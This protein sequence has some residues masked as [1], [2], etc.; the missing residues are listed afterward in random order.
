MRALDLD[1]VDRK[2]SPWAGWVLLGVAVLL[3]AEMVYSYAKL[4]QTSSQRS[5]RSTP[6]IP[7]TR[8]S[9]SAGSRSDERSGLEAQ[10]AEAAAVIER[11]SLPWPQ[12]F[13]ALERISLDRVALLSIQ[14]DPERRVVTLVGEA[15]QYG[16]VL[17]YINGLNEVPVFGHARL[18]SHEIKQ[19][20]PQRPVVFTVAASW[21]IGP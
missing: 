14:P 11:L 5:A 1:F 6:G 4:V 18:V 12:L 3:A 9:A 13:Q 7:M 8:I 2:R 20:D 19:D 21:K 16:D 17:G 15:K 10:A